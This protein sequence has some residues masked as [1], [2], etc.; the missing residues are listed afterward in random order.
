MGAGTLRYGMR[1]GRDLVLV[2]VLVLA[3]A[4]WPKA[5]GGWVKDAQG[6]M[7]TTVRA[8]VWHRD[9]A[10]ARAGVAAVME[11]MRRIDGLMSPYKAHSELAQ[12]NAQAARRAVPVGPD[13]LAVVQRAQ[14][15]SELTHGAHL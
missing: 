3:L 5:Q 2:L 1:N 6:V 13:M 4:L 15:F 10:V 11:E 14:R 12:V 7:G 8:E 9:E